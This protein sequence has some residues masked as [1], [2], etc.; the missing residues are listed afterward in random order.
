MNDVRDTLFGEIHADA[1]QLFARGRAAFYAELLEY[2]AEDIFLDAGFTPKKDVIEGIKI[3]SRNQGESDEDIGVLASRTYT[4][5]RETGWLIE[6]KQGFHRLTDFE[7]SARMLLDF[8]LD[9]K[10]G[11]LRSYGSEVIQV[12]SLIESADRDPENRSSALSGAAKSARGFLNHLRSLSAGMRK[13]E[14]AINALTDFTVLFETFFKSYVEK[15]LIEDYKTIHTKANPFRYRVRILELANAILEDD[16]K[17]DILSKAYV[18]EARA[19]GPQRAR[20][21]VIADLRRVLQVFDNIDPYLDIIEET[22]RRV[23]V[24]I[25]NTVRFLD[26]I[27]EANTETLERVIANLG[28]KDVETVDVIPRQTFAEIP[29]G[30]M[31]LFSPPPA[32][33][34]IVPQEIVRPEKSPE[35]MQWELALL[36]YRERSLINTDK[37]EDYLKRSFGSR[38]QMKGSELPINSLDDFFV[39][40]RIRSLEHLAG[41]E[42]RQRWGIEL[43]REYIE[44]DWII[45]RDF[46]ISKKQKEGEAV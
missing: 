35:R 41:G 18:K 45:C 9:F 1:F 39:F 16:F 20:E 8:L 10:S 27:E 12:L 6:Q 17:I 25:R 46:I 37:I 34:A 28:E 43:T 13:A 7:P 42:M 21:M 26:Q 36:T 15:F 5:L 38:S 44:T 14:E 4:R 40:E 23:E 31:H 19:A 3:F 24:R 30:N 22:N 33:E 29:M 2:L 11:R 32:R